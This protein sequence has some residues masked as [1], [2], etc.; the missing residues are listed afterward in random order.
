[1]IRE[2]KGENDKLKRILM[3]AAK[4]GSTVLDLKALGLDGDMDFAFPLSGD[5]KDVS[6]Q[7]T[8]YEQKIQEME[9]SWEER[10][11]IQKQKDQV[12]REK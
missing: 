11:K 12:E 2:L 8:E 6:A 7:I 1:M 10:L 9:S 5:V 3:E 4:N